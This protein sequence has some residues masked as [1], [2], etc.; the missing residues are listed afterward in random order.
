MRIHVPSISACLLQF[1]LTMPPAIVAAQESGEPV[2]EEADIAANNSMARIGMLTQVVG[3]VGLGD[4]DG[5]DSN[6]FSL[7]AARVRLSGDLDRGFS[8]FSEF[9]FTDSPAVLDALIGLEVSPALSIDAGLFKVPFSAEHLVSTSATD[10]VDRAQVARSIDR[11]RQVGVT[12]QGASPGTGLG[13]NVGLFTGGDPPDSGRSRLYVGRLTAAPPLSA[14]N[15]EAAGIMAYG[16]E[17]DA[18]R[19]LA[20]GDSRYSNGRLLLSAEVI[21]VYHDAGSGPDSLRTS[22]HVTAGFMLKPHRHQVLA[23][24]DG[25]STDRA[26]SEQYILL[27]YNAWPAQG[28]RVQLNY[29]I[30]ARGKRS[31]AHRVL[32]KIQVA[33]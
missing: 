31:G 16:D 28:V 8:Y 24:W 7:A 5:Q 20:G 1:A 4:A 23:R 15:L 33:I 12:V 27:G 22:Y 2:R 30:P 18:T 3:D 9:D 32:L 19:I 10:F 29:I 14:G 11:G 6:G 17:E 26:G 25:L 21:R 13:Y